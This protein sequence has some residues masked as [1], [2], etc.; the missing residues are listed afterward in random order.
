MQ[1]N[2]DDVFEEDSPPRL[3][4]RV[5][6]E[7]KQPTSSQSKADCQVKR[8]KGVTAKVTP[9]VKSDKAKKHVDKNCNMPSTPA[10]DDDTQII[11]SNESD[12]RNKCN[13]FFW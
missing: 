9:N 7:Q 1:T 11:T 6:I 8:C 2:D 10:F 3:R 13:F 4:S 5:K 12:V